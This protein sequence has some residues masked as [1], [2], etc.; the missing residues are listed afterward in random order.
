MVVLAG[1]PA[2]LSKCD[3]LQEKS[4]NVADV[5]AVIDEALG[6]APAVNDLNAD[7][8]VNVADIQIIINAALGWGCAA[9]SLPAI[10]TLAPKATLAG[11]AFTLTVTGTN[12]AGATFT[13]SPPL[14]ITSATI[15]AGGTT[16]TLVVSPPA[17]AKGYYTLIGTSTTG[18]PS[19]PIPFSYRWWA[20]LE[21]AATQGP[22]ELAEELF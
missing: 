10:L 15:N 19:S 22:G 18:G 5:Q 21:G 17:S 20:A 3:I 2:S 13:F 12:L 11:S 6:V 8:G 14:T 7:G 16:A 4:P 1:E 9:D